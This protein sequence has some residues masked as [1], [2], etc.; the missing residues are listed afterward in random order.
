MGSFQNLLEQI[1]THS[2]FKVLN[3]VWSVS[4]FT[5]QRCWWRSFE[6]WVPK[7]CC[8]EPLWKHS[9]YLRPASE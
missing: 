2:F 5:L 1:L 3:L 6:S 9:T 4:L 7:Q 8:R